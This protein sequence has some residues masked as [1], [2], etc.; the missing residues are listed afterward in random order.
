MK[1]SL[2]IVMDPFAVR[3]FDQ[4]LT[5]PSCITYDHEKF[6][7]KV[8]DYYLEVKDKGGLKEGYAP[9]CKHL[10]MENFT[11]CLSYY[12]KIEPEND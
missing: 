6:T 3:Q 1:K 8:N 2:K 5:G 10:F 11:D 4:Q 9:F 7:E 12:I